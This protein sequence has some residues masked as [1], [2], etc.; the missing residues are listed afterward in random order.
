VGGSPVVLPI[1]ATP[2][3]VTATVIAPA[4]DTW[5]DLTIEVSAVTGAA[6]TFTAIYVAEDNLTTG[7][8]PP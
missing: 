8:L 5:Y 3:L 4:L 1:G 7:D 6:P 2:A